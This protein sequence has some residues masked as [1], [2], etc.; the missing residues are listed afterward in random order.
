MKSNARNGGK[1]RESIDEEPSS[2]FSTN[3]NSYYYYY[4]RSPN[5]KVQIENGN[6]TLEGR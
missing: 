6:H 4:A 1:T 3:G 5:R 2:I